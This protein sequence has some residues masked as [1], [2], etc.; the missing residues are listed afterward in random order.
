MKKI[1]KYSLLILLFIALYGQFN[2]KHQFTNIVH[3]ATYTECGYIEHIC[4]CGFSYKDHY[5]S[6]TSN[7]VNNNINEYEEEK[8]KKKI[9][10]VLSKINYLIFIDK[11]LIKLNY[12]QVINK[13]FEKEKVYIIYMRF[14]GDL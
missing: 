7:N 2:H 4:E 12:K 3:E 11:C 5:V 10:F 13:V 14:K 9:N 8:V 6:S 1:I